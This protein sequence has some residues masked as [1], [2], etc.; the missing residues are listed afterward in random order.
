[1]I[2][3]MSAVFAP[4]VYI[5]AAAGI[6]QGL[7]IVVSLIDADI[8]TT[9]TFAVLNFMSWTPFAFCRYLSPSRRRA[10]SNVT[11]LSLFFAAVR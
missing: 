9:G 4:I 7:L 2:A 6:L 11:R 5:L 3:T 10:I 8:K 1:V